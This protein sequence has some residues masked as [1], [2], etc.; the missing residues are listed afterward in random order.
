[1]AEAEFST[2]VGKIY[3]FGDSL[4]YL[5]YDIAP[6]RWTKASFNPQGVYEGN[7]RYFGSCFVPN[8]KVYLTGGSSSVSAI[9]TNNVLAVDLWYITDKP[10][11]KNKMHKARYGH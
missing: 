11:K 2:D 1:M 10:M 6:M 4:N 5:R 8:R 7:L 3:C 9:A